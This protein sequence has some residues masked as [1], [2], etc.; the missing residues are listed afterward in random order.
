MIK[1][2]NRQKLQINSINEKT[3]TKR[4]GFRQTGTMKITKNRC[5]NTDQ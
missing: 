5:Y 1:S 3:N 2:R 4:N